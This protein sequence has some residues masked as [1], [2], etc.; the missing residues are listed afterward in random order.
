MKL[1]AIPY[2]SAG[3]VWILVEFRAPKIQYIFGGPVGNIGKG[4]GTPRGSLGKSL[5]PVIMITPET[6]GWVGSF[7]ENPG[8]RPDSII[9][10]P[11]WN[12]GE[13][14]FIRYL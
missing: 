11:F 2:R 1:Q 12:F 14:P 3:S 8:S 9:F 7:P 6:S 13:A 10:C 5:M 4:F